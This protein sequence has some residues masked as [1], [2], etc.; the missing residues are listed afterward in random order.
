[1]SQNNG[2]VFR[3]AET[4]DDFQKIFELQN[5]NI[6]A[7]LSKNDLKNGFLSGSFTL[8]QLRAVNDNI[9]IMTCFASLD[10]CG[11]HIASTPEFNKTSP[12]LMQ[13]MQQ[14]NK[15][16]YKGKKLSEYACFIAGPTCIA[17]EYRGQNIYPQ[18]IASSFDFL[19]NTRNPARLRISFASELNPRSLNAQQK[20]GC[21][22][23]GEF[24]FNAHKFMLLCLDLEDI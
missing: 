7:A 5:Q 16:N 18:L 1:M 12:L 2:L 14:F 21:E 8:E 24:E 20:N 6:V 11:Y 3:R 23:I 13:M 10:L 9:C 15:I 19:K 17:K 22:I 4:A